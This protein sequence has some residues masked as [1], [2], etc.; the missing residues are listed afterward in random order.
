MEE[1]V[2]SEVEVTDVGK[3]MAFLSYLFFFGFLFYRT[4]KENEYVMFHARQ[5]IVLFLLPVIVNIVL[6]VVPVV[7]QIV[8]FFFNIAVFILFIMGSLNALSGKMAELPL[9]GKIAVNFIK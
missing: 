5:G 8:G 6:L 2:N 9:F 3:I 4:Q 7:G 1:V